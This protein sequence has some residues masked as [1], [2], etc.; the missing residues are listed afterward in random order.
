MVRG[1][2]RTALLLVATF[3]AQ[4]LSAADFSGKWVFEFD[5]PDGIVNAPI[6]LVQNGESLSATIA[7]QSLKGRAHE[8]GF[9]LT[10]DFFYADAGYSAPLRITGKPQ[11]EGLAG[12]ASWDAN[13][14]TFTA[15]RAD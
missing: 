14:L 2:I 11:G 6:E 12:D 3:S 1:F 10:G 8:D 5:T 4:A 13:P 15:K 9:E 7:D